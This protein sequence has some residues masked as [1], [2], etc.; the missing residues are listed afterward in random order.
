VSN[1]NEYFAY[2]NNEITKCNHKKITPKIKIRLRTHISL[3][4]ITGYCYI[5]DFLNDEDNDDVDDYDYGRELYYLFEEL[6]K[7]V[8]TVKT[9]KNWIIQK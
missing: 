1:I 3:F 2:L 8:F 6:S 5:H 4:K 9:Y 7:Y